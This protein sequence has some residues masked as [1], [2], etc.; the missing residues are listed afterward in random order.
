[1]AQEFRRFIL[2]DDTK[3]NRDKFNQLVIEKNLSREDIMFILTQ[4]T[5][6]TEA[7]KNLM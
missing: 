6:N 1:M 3:E 4:V 2:I 7:L 5:L